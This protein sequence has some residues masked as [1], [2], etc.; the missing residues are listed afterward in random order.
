MC[1]YDNDADKKTKQKKLP[2][3]IRL[4]YIFVFVFCNDTKWDTASL[5]KHIVIGMVRV[6]LN[7]KTKK[8]D[9][10]SFL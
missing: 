9:D 10:L 5:I 8:M 1:P 2:S 3:V 6:A 4:H 7:P